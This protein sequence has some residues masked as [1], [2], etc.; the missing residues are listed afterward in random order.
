MMEEAIAL[1]WEKGKIS[2]EEGKERGLIVTSWAADPKLEEF[3]ILFS[4]V[5]YIFFPPFN[6]GFTAVFI[7]MFYP[8]LSFHF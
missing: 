1:G 8:L 3:P 5:S 4:I 7:L 2:I 6:I